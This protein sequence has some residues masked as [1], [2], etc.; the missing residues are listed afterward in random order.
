MASYLDILRL[1]AVNRLTIF[2]VGLV[3]LMIAVD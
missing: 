1:G 3:M 2:V